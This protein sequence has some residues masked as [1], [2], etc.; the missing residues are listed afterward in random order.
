MDISGNLSGIRTSQIRELQKLCDLKTERH[1]LINS[2][3]AEGMARITQIWNREIAIF[4]SRS[5]WVFA[6]SVGKHASVHLPVIGERKGG[7]LR[8]I[9]THPKG[10]SDLS[11]LDLSALSDLGLESMTSLAVREGKVHGIQLAYLQ[12]G[13]PE[14][15]DLNPEMLEDFNY[16]QFAQKVRSAGSQKTALI[17]NNQERAFLIGLSEDNEDDAEQNFLDELKELSLT[18]GV[19]VVGQLLQ[20]RRFSQSS[21]YL[22][23]GKLEE[24]CRLI[25]E[26]EATVLICDDELSPRQMRTLEQ[27]SGVKV[28]DR[29]SLILDIF[30][31]RARSREGKLQVELAQLKHL[32]PSLTGQGSILSRLGGGVGTRGPGESKLEL[33]RRRVRNRIT[34]LEKELVAVQQERT[35]QRQKR[36]KSG[37]PLISLVGYT[38]AGKTTFMQKAL[39]QTGQYSG[40]PVGE[41]QL[42]ATL[43]PIIRRIRLTTGRNILLSDTVGFIKK[44]PPKLLK[45]FLATLEEVQ[46]ADVLVHLLDAS[47]PQA[48]IQAQTVQNVLRE[49]GCENKPTITVLNKIDKVTND[50]EVSRLA[51]QVDNPQAISLLKGDSLTLIWERIIQLLPA[52][53]YNCNK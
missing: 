38:N 18:A 46:Q 35:V 39:E 8:C 6:V 37:I 47:H 42:F 4:I 29:T 27:A 5:G 24:V 14:T 51:Q 44:L 52:D 49:L 11:A 3:L 1:K 30:S 19:K 50:F 10:N 9:H 28:L 13:K 26:Q 21:S 16:S 23:K 17:H 33:D 12:E 41:N 15:L 43:D 20:S 32:L 45:A 53:I 31:L 2:D 36:L 34:Q 48:I 22:G 40:I 7:K 25:Q